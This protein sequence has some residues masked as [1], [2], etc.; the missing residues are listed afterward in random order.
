MQ[1][2]TADQ[3]PVL[4]FV[5]T[6]CQLQLSTLGLS[7]AHNR[8]HSCN[9]S[10]PWYAFADLQV[11]M[12][13]ELGLSCLCEGRLWL[14]GAPLPQALAAACFCSSTLICPVSY[15]RHCCCNMLHTLGE[16]LSLGGSE[17]RAT[18]LTLGSRLMHLTDLCKV[19]QHPSQ[20]SKLGCRVTGEPGA[21]RDVH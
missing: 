11:V 14:A 2:S 18:G 10:L 6:G 4:K 7:K 16:H 19:G 20:G 15:A 13:L 1:R 3:T 5:C 8:E 12:H 17:V 9:P 21:P